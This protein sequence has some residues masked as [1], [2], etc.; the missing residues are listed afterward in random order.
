MSSWGRL[1]GEN[2]IH[3][4]RVAL[5]PWKA[6]MLRG[7][8]LRVTSHRILIEGLAEIPLKSITDC[9]VKYYWLLAQYVE[10]TFFDSMGGS[11]RLRLLDR[12]I[13]FPDERLPWAKHLEKVIV[14]DWQAA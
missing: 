3:H 10:L 1:N 5:S 13:A 8:D 7:R 4:D 14:D 2:I 11:Q 9:Q 12:R 6:M